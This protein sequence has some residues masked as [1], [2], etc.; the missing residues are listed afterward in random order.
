MF[1]GRTT[2]MKELLGRALVDAVAE[3]AG[4]PR[5]NVQVVFSDIGTDDW[6]IGPTLVSSRPP[7]PAPEYI[8]ALMVVERLAL[9]AGKSN[10]YLAW[11]RDA[12][13]PFLAT[14]PGFLSSALLSVGEDGYV[15]VEKWTTPEAR[16]KSLAHAGA[17]ALRAEEGQFVESSSQDVAGRVVDVLRGRS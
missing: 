17:A 4:P 7:A 5:D 15:V 12:V 11:R 6:A 1:R 8:A 3:I 9:K 14:Q 10:D 2:V 13:L 16:E